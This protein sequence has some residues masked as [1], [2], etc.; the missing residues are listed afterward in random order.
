MRNMMMLRQV[1]EVL[2]QVVPNYRINLVEVNKIRDTRKFKSD[3]QIIFGMLQYKSN[4]E[5]LL[6]YTDEHR[7][8]FSHMDYES[9]QVIAT[10]LNARK[11]LGRIIAKKGVEDNMCQALQE[12]YEDGV[13]DGVEREKKNT[14]LKMLSKGFDTE[15]ISELSGLTFEEIEKLRCEG[16][17]EN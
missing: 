11:L 16:R 13:Q 17:K 6:N 1:A 4:K 5:G 3:L 10:L 9:Q 2:A 8:Y 7:A 14:V 15:L 12:L